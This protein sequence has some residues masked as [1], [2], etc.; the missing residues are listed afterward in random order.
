MV[1]SLQEPVSRVLL[2]EAR[3]HKEAAERSLAEHSAEARSELIRASTGLEDVSRAIPSNTALVAFVQYERSGTQKNERARG[4][5][6]L[7]YAAFAMRAGSHQVHFVSI[8]NAAQIDSLIKAWRDEASGRSLE[9]GQARTVAERT[10]D[11]ASGHLR[12]AVWDPLV[13]HVDGTSRVFVVPDG[14]L[15]LVNLAALEDHDGRYLAEAATAI[16]YLTTERDLLLQPP[17]QRGASTLL[18]VGGP[19]FD[20][21][22]PAAQT[23]SARRA[24]ECPSLANARFE[25]LPG[26]LGEVTEISAIWRRSNNGRVTLLQG[27]AAT[28]S[29]VKG[30]LAGHRIVH[31]ATHGFFLGKDCAS[32]VA[33]GRRAVGGLAAASTV[34]S[35]LIENPLLLTGLA[36]AGANNRSEA[37]L[38]QDEGLLTAEEIAGLN[39]RGTEWAVLSACD[40]GLG[41]IKAGEGVFGLRR[42]FQIAGARTVIMSLWSVEDESAREWMRA[43]YEER[44]VRRLDTAAAVREAGLTVLRARRAKGLSTHPFYWAAFVAAGD[45]R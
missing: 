11:E 32:E 23:A 9:A 20:G 15:N 12:R 14:L 26:S 41:E 39:L 4:S 3:E 40:T 29:A 43:L 31:L 18:A 8:G 33:A 21:L 30:A 2:D 44:L 45:W 10:Y 19:A 17:D 36:F 6:E 1:R 22:T 27:S 25:N 16:H 34:D 7:W 42:A 38:D 37:T 24:A 28:E 35:E 13:P 5:S